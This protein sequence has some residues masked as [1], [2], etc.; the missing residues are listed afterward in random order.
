MSLQLCSEFQN[1]QAKL[2][3]GRLTVH[4]F[5]FSSYKLLVIVSFFMLM[6]ILLLKVSIDLVLYMRMDKLP[7]LQHFLCCVGLRGGGGGG[8]QVRLLEWECVFKQNE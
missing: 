6:L 3:D 7:R 8:K 5:S 2:N 1:V 4:F